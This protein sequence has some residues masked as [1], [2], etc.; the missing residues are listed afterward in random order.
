MKTKF[1]HSPLIHLL[2]LGLVAF[3]SWMA[4]RSSVDHFVRGGLFL[5]GI[6]V[7]GCG[8]FALLTLALYLR[9]GVNRYLVEEG[10]LRIQRLG[11]NTFHAWSEISRIDHNQPLH[12]LVIQGRDGALAL[13]STDYFPRLMDFVRAIYLRSRCEL[14]PSLAEMLASESNETETPTVA[15]SMGL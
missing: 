1:N 15:L 5:R 7:G 14:S 11:Q 12:Y 13:T 6:M 4:Y 2:A 8:L 10:G 9:S 3:F